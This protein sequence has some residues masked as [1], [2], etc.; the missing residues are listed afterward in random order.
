M[1]NT[2]VRFL[3][4]LTGVIPEKLKQNCRTWLLDYI[5]GSLISF[6]ISDGDRKFELTCYFRNM[7][8][9]LF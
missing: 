1:M 9:I 8:Q 3:N 7:I 6:D 2:M 5:E 4:D